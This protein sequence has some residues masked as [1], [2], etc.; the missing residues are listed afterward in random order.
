VSGFDDARVDALELLRLAQAKLL[1]AQTSGSGE[2]WAKQNSLSLISSAC[3]E[4]RKAA[5]VE[6]A[7]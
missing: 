4:L 2:Y 6:T 3:A 5:P 7:Q 1:T